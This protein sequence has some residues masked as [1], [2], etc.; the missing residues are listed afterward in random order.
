MFTTNH[1]DRLDEALVRPGRVDMS[2]KLGHATQY[3]IE[4]AVDRFYAEF[5]VDGRG[6]MRSWKR[7]KTGLADRISTAALQGLFLHNKDSVEGA[8]S[9]VGDLAGASSR[10]DLE[11]LHKSQAY[12]KPNWKTDVIK[13]LRCAVLFVKA[14]C[15]VRRGETTKRKQAYKLATAARGVKPWRVLVVNTIIPKQM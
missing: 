5:D 7:S 9:A 2:V 14:Y 4:Q 8:M 6:K 15:H 3:Q 12:Q 10:L 13:I 1:V 11:E